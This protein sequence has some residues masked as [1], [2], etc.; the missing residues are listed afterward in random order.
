MTEYWFTERVFEVD[1]EFERSGT[2][3]VVASI[4]VRDQVT[5]KHISVT[6]RPDGDS[7]S[8]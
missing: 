1:D 6:V 5:D 2:T 3:W 7:P 8:T 4:G